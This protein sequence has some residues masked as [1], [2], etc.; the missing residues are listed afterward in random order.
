MTVIDPFDTNKRDTKVNVSS[1]A[2][3]RFHNF[4][5]VTHLLGSFLPYPGRR[6]GPVTRV[7]VERIRVVSHR[8]GLRHRHFERY[9]CSLTE[10][11]VT[12][13][14]RVI[15]RQSRRKRRYVKNVYVK[16]ENLPK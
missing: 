12:D 14:V 5:G 10:P 13:W 16:V 4:F 9:H 15:Y 11:G 1:L 3:A 6:T 2:L 8:N 7:R